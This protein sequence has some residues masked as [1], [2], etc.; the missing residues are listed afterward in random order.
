MPN[1]AEKETKIWL[2]ANYNMLD[3][4]VEQYSDVCS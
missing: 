1:G 3:M 2:D 4:W